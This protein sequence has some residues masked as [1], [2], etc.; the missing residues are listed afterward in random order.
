MKMKKENLNIIF[1]ILMAICIFLF[2]YTIIQFI[3]NKELIT[4][5]PITY[6]MEKYNFTYC[7]C[8]D[9]QGNIWK[10]TDNGFI[11]GT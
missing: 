10:S 1:L 2:I 6:G 3:K 9:N 5:S 7:Q 8:V 4:Q 11:K